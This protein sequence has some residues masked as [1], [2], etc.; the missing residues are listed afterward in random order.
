MLG[1]LVVSMKWGFAHPIRANGAH[2]NYRWMLIEV[3]AHGITTL[4]T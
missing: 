1:P 3:K 2:P 4:R